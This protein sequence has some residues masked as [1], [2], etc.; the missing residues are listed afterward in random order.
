MG[1]WLFQKSEDGTCFLRS[2]VPALNYC[3]ALHPTLGPSAT[4]KDYRF[5]GVNYPLSSNLLLIFRFCRR[6]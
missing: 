2:A 5:Y 3:Y 4:T 6:R 1:D